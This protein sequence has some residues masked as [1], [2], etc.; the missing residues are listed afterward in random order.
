VVLSSWPPAPEWARL[1]DAC[2]AFPIVAIDG[3]I[4]ELS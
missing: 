4:I 2:A 1:A 3:P